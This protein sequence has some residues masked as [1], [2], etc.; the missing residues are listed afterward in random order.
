MRV[1]SVLKSRLKIRLLSNLYQSNAFAEVM[2]YVLARRGREVPSFVMQGIGRR[3]PI[4]RDL[5]RG[6]VRPLLVVKACAGAY[7]KWP[8]VARLFV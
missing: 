3:D 4:A 5:R 2:L 7:C 1:T 8:C 6:S